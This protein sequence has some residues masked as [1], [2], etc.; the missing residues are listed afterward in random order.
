VLDGDRDPAEVAA[1]VVAATRRRGM[2]RA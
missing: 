1:D 2:L